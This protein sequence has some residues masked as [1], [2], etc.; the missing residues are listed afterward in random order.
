MG[1]YK[2]I[3]SGTFISLVPLRTAGVPVFQTEN[4]CFLPFLSPKLLSVSALG[5][6]RMP[7]GFFN[8]G[9]LFDLDLGARDFFRQVSLSGEHFSNHA[10]SDCDGYGRGRAPG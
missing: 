7:L 3:F 1:K 8:L 4:C 10:N 2:K 9:I 6:R 5:L